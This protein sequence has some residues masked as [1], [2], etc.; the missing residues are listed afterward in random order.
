MVCKCKKIVVSIFLA[1][2]CNCDSVVLSTLAYL[3]AGFD[4]ASKNEILQVLNLRVSPC[5]IIFANPC[6]QISH[7]Q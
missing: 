2:K 1:V 5:D 6:K 7:I 4:C 3:G